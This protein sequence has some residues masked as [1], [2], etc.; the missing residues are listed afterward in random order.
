[1]KVNQ[2]ANLKI[3]LMMVNY[4]EN[5]S[6]S[7]PL[8]K[9]SSAPA[10]NTIRKRLSPKNPPKLKKRKIIVDPGENEE[11]IP[12]EP[13]MAAILLEIPNPQPKKVEP[14]RKEWSINRFSIDSIFRIPPDE[15]TIYHHELLNK[16]NAQQTYNHRFH[17]PGFNPDSLDVSVGH[18]FGY[19]AVRRSNG[20]IIYPEQYPIRGADQNIMPTS[21]LGKLLNRMGR[22]RK[23]H[24][25]PSESSDLIPVDI[26]SQVILRCSEAISCRQLCGSTRPIDVATATRGLGKNQVSMASFREFTLNTLYKNALSILGRIASEDPRAQLV[27]GSLEIY[28]QN[29]PSAG[30]HYPFGRPERTTLKE[31][32]KPD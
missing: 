28:T 27:F 29:A 13:L 20:A 15:R 32:V 31:F 2:L 19:F 30:V 11:I 24:Q 17:M 23:F 8:A 9:M 22:D 14:E 18:S 3:D 16:W 4:L 21:E 6:F 10:T 26:H 5:P 7:M 12:L 1:V 25:A